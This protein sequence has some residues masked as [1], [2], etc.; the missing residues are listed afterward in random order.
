MVIFKCLKLPTSFSTFHSKHM[1]NLL[2]TRTLKR[3]ISQTWSDEQMNE[4]AI[5]VRNRWGGGGGSIRNGMYCSASGILNKCMYKCQY[6]QIQHQY[7]TVYLYNI[8]YNKQ[9]CYNHALNTRTTKTK[10][11]TGGRR[12]KE[13]PSPPLPHVSN[14]TTFFCSFSFHF[15]DTWIY[16]YTGRRRDD[17][18]VRMSAPDSGI[19]RG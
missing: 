17:V 8:R 7:T 18:I 3:Q 15:S 10:T 16:I 11:R 6:A 9:I 14:R 5:N 12:E 19:Q 13:V 4:S 2:K 1:V